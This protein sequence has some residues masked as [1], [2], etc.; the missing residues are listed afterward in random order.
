VAESLEHERCK[1]NFRT[2]TRSK[3]RCWTWCRCFPFPAKFPAWLEK[4]QESGLNLLN[5]SL[6]PMRHSLIDRENSLFLGLYQG[7]RLAPRHMRPPPS[8]FALWASQDWRLS[9]SRSRMVSETLAKEGCRWHRATPLRLGGRQFM[10]RNRASR[11]NLRN[12]ADH[13][14]RRFSAGFDRL[15]HGLKERKG[16][17]APDRRQM[18][19]PG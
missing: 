16:P 17:F 13:H 9:P 18:I 6:A 5:N 2:Y 14:V 4:E 11:I 10:E 8:G 7:I 1:G 15:Q 12:V 3:P 19:N